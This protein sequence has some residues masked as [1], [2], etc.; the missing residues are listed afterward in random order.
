MSAIFSCKCSI[1][2]YDAILPCDN[3]GG[4]DSRWSRVRP[5]PAASVRRLRPPH[6]QL[7]GGPSRSPLSRLAPSHSTPSPAAAMRDCAQHGCTM[8]PARAARGD[9][10]DAML[11]RPTLPVDDITQIAAN[12]A[13]ARRRIAPP[14][15]VK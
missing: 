1:V 9:R 4:S 11:D 3:P 13:L 14:G 5:D 2:V 12:S 10:E 6:D 8:R 7:F 15:Y